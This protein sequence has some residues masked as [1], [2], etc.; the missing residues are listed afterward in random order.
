M[1]V[2]SLFRSRFERRLD[3]ACLALPS[4]AGW[5][6]GD[7]DLWSGRFAGYM[8]R[9]GVQA[10]DRVA[11][12]VEKSLAGVALYLGALR[13][14]AVFTPLNTAYTPHEVAF[15]LEDGAPRLFFCTPSA[16]ASLE[17]VAAKAGARLIALGDSDDDALLAE[18]AAIEPLPPT[19]RAENDLAVILYTSGTT[20]RS[21][22]AMLTHGNLA[23]N[24]LALNRLWG[25]SG[26]DVLLHA[27]PIFHI[28]GLFVAL[29][30]ALLSAATILFLPRF[31]PGDVRRLLPGATVMMGVPTFYT[32]LLD[33]PD[34]GA[35]DCSSI[36]LFVCGSAPLSAR[37]WTRFRERTGHEILER[38]GMTEAGMIA[39]N[40]LDGARIAGSVGFALPGVEARVCDGEGR[41]LP[42]G[43]TG[44]IEVRGPNVFKGYWGLPEKTAEEFRPDGF[45]ITGDVGTMDENGRLRIVGRSKDLIISGGYNIYPKEIESVLDDIPGIAESAV[46]GAPHKDLGEGVVAVLVAAGGVPLADIQAALDRH[47]ARFKHPRRFFFEP[48]LPR[49]A[50]GKVEKAALRAKYAG[51][52]D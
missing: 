30:T 4:R 35:A 24:A 9:A 42:R 38:Y 25:F 7:L 40:P 39:S 21:K 41:E 5:T 19:A 28:H 22:G 50:M 33:D 1:N 14:G 44:V 16:A 45:F 51:A 2:Y 3:R 18:I 43:E 31:D 17:G 13:L 27:L 48:S 34:F 37:D 8:A 20:G 36:R 46:I 15:F 23:S 52:Y 11:A 32:R 49:N 6:Y 10:G 47:L 26:E 12:Q 29:H